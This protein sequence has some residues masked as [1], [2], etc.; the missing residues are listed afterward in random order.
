MADTIESFVARLQADGLDEGRKQAEQIKKQAAQDAAAIVKAARDQADRIL[1]DA[2][3]ESHNL[4]ERGRTELQLACRDTLLRLRDALG[5]AVTAV[6]SAGTEKTLRDVELIGRILHEVVLT[7]A[8]ADIDGDRRI[9][10]NVQPEMREQLVNWA[11]TEIKQER[12]EGL[13]TSIDLRGSLKT[14]GFEY[15]LSGAKVEVTRDSVVQVLRELIGPR[16]RE[17]MDKA[18][19]DMASGPSPSTGEEESSES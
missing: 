4:L 1:A 11:L 19:G 18:A 6:L 8:K 7:Y 17:I 12:V 9:M 2:R 13:D 16:L 5:Q 3:R 10:I 15:A 14:A